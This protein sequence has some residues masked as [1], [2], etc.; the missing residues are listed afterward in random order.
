L[1]LIL[2]AGDPKL[3]ENTDLVRDYSKGNYPTADSLFER[4]VLIAIA[5]CLTRRDED[6]I[7]R[8]FEKVLQALLP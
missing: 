3:A 7:I 6:D 2:A 4:S 8:A 5:S 1:E